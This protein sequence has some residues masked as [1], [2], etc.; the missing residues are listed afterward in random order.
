MARNIAFEL[1]YYKTFAGGLNALT[2]ANLVSD[3]ELVEARNAVVGDGF[4]QKRDGY[5]RVNTTA[6]TEPVNGVFNAYRSNGT[7]EMVV[8]TPTKVYKVAGNA[9]TQVPF[10]GTLTTLTGTA[11]DFISYKDRT[12]ADVTLIADGGKLKAYNYTNVSEVAAYTPPAPVGTP[13]VQDANDKGTNDLVNLR[14]RAIEI[15]KDRI[16]SASS[17]TVKNRVNFCHRDVNLGYAAY[18]YWPVSYFIDVA[19]DEND[20]IV[21]LKVFRDYLIIFCKRS[22]WALAGDG[23]T[24]NDYSLTRINVPKGCI[25]ANSVQVVE[26]E[27]FYLAEDGVYALFATSMNTVSAKLVSTNVAPLLSA[28]PLT[29]RQKASAVYS[30]HQYILSIPDTGDT[31]MFDTIH[32]AWTYWNNVK[33]NCFTVTGGEVFFGSDAGLLY[34]FA[35]GTW[36][37]DGTA[38]DFLIRTRNNDFGKPIWLKQ[39]IK[40]VVKAK[41]YDVPQTNITM[42]VVHN[43]AEYAVPLF[44]ADQSFVWDIGNWDQTTLDFTEVATVTNWISKQ[45]KEI[46]YILRNNTVD[47]PCVIYQ[48]D[49]QYMTLKI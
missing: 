30:N 29:S 8:T 39:L 10:G 12:V 7:Q 2:S 20:E 24:M 26:N 38:I 47:Q 3:N 15:K 28:I 1:H 5:T 19:A 6:L 18:D 45:G 21:A 9:M 13:P 25:A 27:I 46:Q 44:S 37:D 31:F 33:A 48:I 36:N 35:P 49:T 11:F 17:P 42:T 16:F 22:V 4:V 23:T 40:V 14:F 32:S 43:G 34:K 41:Q